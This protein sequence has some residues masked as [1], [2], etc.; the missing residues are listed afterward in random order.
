MKNQIY[1]SNDTYKFYEAKIAELEIIKKE[2]R[3]IYVIGQIYMLKQILA[4]AIILP[5]EESWNE[6]ISATS[7]YTRI[8]D[9]RKLYPKGVI[10]QLKQ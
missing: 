7:E 9:L 8:Q 6:T 4:S 1:M 10:I 2:T 3:D 5:V